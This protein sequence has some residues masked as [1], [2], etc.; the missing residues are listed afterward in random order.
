MRHLVVMA[1]AP[2]AGQ[3][4]TRLA[5]TIGVERA[6]DLYSGFLLDTMSTASRVAAVRFDVEVLV[7][8]APDGSWPSFERIG[9]AGTSK[10][11]QRGTD[12]GERI[13]NCFD[14]LNALGSSA[15]VIIGA[16]SPTLSGDLIHEAFDALASGSDLVLGPTLDG[17]YYLI[18]A[19]HLHA[20]LF[21]GVAWSSSSVFRSTLERAAELRLRLHTLPQWYDVDES[22]DLDRLISDLEGDISNCR[23]TRRILARDTAP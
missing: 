22:T 3:V 2:V 6:T 4:K 10:L 9:L 7:C 5:A 8:Y 14:D 19:R 18:A 20:H 11:P 17:G 16:D 15:V 13:G 21:E 1:K 12:L 23:H